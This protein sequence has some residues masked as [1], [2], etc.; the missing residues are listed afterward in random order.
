MTADVLAA[1]A[2]VVPPESDVGSWGLA[3]IG[4]IGRALAASSLVVL[5]LLPAPSA[6]AQQTR[7]Q[8]PPAASTTQPELRPT[9]PPQPVPPGELPR[10]SVQADVST[11]SVAVTS[12]FTGTEIVVFG[13]VDNSRQTSA[14]AGL[15][16]VVIIL[17]GAGTEIVVRRKSNIAGIW[18]NT[19]SLTFVS[20]PSYYAIASTRPLDEIAAPNV[21]NEN[22]IGFQHVRMS[23]VQGWET[24][25]T[26]ADLQVFRDAVIRLK[27]RDGLYTRDEYDVTFIGRS[28]FRATI[29]LPAN[30]PVGLLNAKVFLFREG[31]LISTYVGR[32]DLERQGLE[33]VLH[34]FAFKQPLWYG[35]ATVVIAVIAGLAAPTLME[36]ARS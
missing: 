1:T 16:D 3:A 23:P 4:R 26:T 2:G 24:G 11:R 32:V 19:Q 5:C 8:R 13:A 10:E 7:R 35:L 21:L 18:V 27:M 12:S 14:E 36:R 22:D 31:Q 9:V 33:R 28:L 6:E 25:L 20:V 30:V 34:D 29:E 17:E 15:Y